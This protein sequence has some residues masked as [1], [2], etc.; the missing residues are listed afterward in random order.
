MRTRHALRG[1]DLLI[2]DVVASS[3]GRRVLL[4]GWEHDV[5]VHHLASGRTS[6]PITTTFDAGGRRLAL[7]DQLDLIVAGAY[8]RHGV[9]AYCARTGAERWRRRD[10]K[11]IQHI[12]LSRDGRLA[13]C[14]AERG[15]MAILHVRT[16]KTWG[17]LRGARALYESRVEPVAVVDTARPYL[18]GAR[19]RLGWIPRLGFAFLDVTFAPGQVCVSDA[20][21]PVRCLRLKDLDEAWRY[22]PPRG[23]H[24]VRL[25]YDR[26]ARCFV[27]IEWNYK[28]GGPHAFTRLSAATGEVVGRWSLRNRAGAAFAGAGRRL[29][30]SDGRILDTTTGKQ[31][32]RY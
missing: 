3:T 19:G 5:A 27:G 21:G 23:W 31:T 25:G 2:D 17:L 32:G 11:Q 30:L 7:S 8:H 6:R 13:Y 12:T 24:A 18:M 10:L 22:Q 20:G 26:A 15:P 1:T 9:A 16:G 29:V 14:G 28:R 4:A